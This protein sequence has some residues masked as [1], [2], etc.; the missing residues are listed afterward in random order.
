[1]HISWGQALSD[2][3]D[4]DTLTS[5]EPARVMVYGKLSFYEYFDNNA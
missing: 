4:L 2:N 5:D 3:H 1:M